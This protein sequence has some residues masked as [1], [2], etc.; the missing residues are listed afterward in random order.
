M[1]RPGN[2]ADHAHGLLRQAIMTAV[3][4]PGERLSEGGLAQRFGLTLGPLRA[5][6]AR[7]RAEGL[8]VARPRAGHVVAPVTVDDVLDVY[9]LRRVLQA[10]ATE[11]AAGRVRRARLLELH[12]ACEAAAGDTAAVL[13][14][15]RAFHQAVTDAAGSPRLSRLVADLL[16]HSERMQ[17]LGL[18]ARG[19]RPLPA[20][21]PALIRALAAGDGAAASSIMQAHLDAIRAMTLEALVANPALRDVPLQASSR[22]RST[23][24]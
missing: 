5:A 3:L 23:S 2:L 7:L 21:R 18:A 15:N 10:H 16:D 1:Q 14:S 6:L 24:A 12:R 8:L 22:M 11:L 17:H 9:A 19:G 20:W 13:R 4:P